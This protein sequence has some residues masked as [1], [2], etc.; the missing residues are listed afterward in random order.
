MKKESTNDD[1]ALQVL[2]RSLH[3]RL[4]RESKLG[5]LEALG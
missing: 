3:I 5:L 2:V 4:A 1:G